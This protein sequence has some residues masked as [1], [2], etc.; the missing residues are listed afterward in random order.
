MWQ[1]RNRQRGSFSAKLKRFTALLLC[2]VARGPA[3]AQVSVPETLKT[4][5]RVTLGLYPNLSQRFIAGE[6][7]AT[8]NE[9]LRQAGRVDRTLLR[10]ILAFIQEPSK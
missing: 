8:L 9:Y 6:G 5:P 1:Y 4:H 10:D 2:L 3:M 7:M